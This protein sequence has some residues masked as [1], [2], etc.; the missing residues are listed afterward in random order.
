M[1]L[2]QNQLD[3]ICGIAWLLLIVRQAC[4][5]LTIWSELDT[6]EEMMATLTQ[7]IPVPCMVHEST[8]ISHHVN[9]LSH[10]SRFLHCIS[11]LP[12]DHSIIEFYVGGIRDIN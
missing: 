11:C 5:P 2:E 6:P 12:S 4:V 7:H 10:M 1:V 3:E 9:C 8:D